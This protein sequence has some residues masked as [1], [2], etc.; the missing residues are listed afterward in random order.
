MDSLGIGLMGY[1]MI[2][3]IHALGYHDLPLLYPRQLPA[4]RLSAVC[5][6][7]PDTAQ[8]AASEAGFAA[9]C[10][11][12]FSLAQ[13]PDVDV[14]DCTL[15]NYLHL[16]ALLAALRAG[17]PVYCEKPLAVNDVE[18]R[19]LTHA[20]R[21]A[22]VPVGLGFN[23][24][25]V[26]AIMRARQLLHDGA[27]GDIFTFRA[28]YL[29]S[30]YQDPRRPMS[31]RLRQEQAGG[32]ASMDLGSH[33][34][35][36]IRH[37]L[38]EFHSVRATLHTFIT[39]RPVQ[40][41]AAQTEAVTVDDAAWIQVRLDSGAL[42]TVETSRFA[43]G[44]VDDLRLEI[45]GRRGALRFS[46]MDG[47]WL[48]WYDAARKAEPLGGER[49]WVRLETL[50]HYPGAA[51]PPPRAILGWTRTHAENQHVFLRAV[52]T[53]AAPHPDVVDGLRAQLVLSAAYTSAR[54]GGWV[55]VAKE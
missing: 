29:H 53:G 20:A 42:G 16:P 18:A 43:T 25:F 7:R 34:V 23:Y 13:R 37:L 12:F 39:E 21:A 1:G 33:V 28:Q 26:P 19:E 22:G 41:D 2:G 35:D 48:Y 51:A 10:T 49:G 11:D 3:R 5:T 54:S 27:L 17:K 24:R 32:G 9:W 52:A 44:M 45:H 14:V 46:L 31:W 15:P 4:L 36:L 50:Q 47:N 30:G 40:R 8:A 6:S 38:G 55:A